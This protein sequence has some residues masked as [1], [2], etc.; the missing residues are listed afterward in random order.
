MKLKQPFSLVLALFLVIFSQ[1]L[2]AWD[3]NDVKK[4]NEAIA[5]F[6]KAD[7]D[8]QAF[9]DQARGYAVFPTVGKG[10]F[11]LGGAYGK[12]VV[13]E[14]GKPIGNTSVT[15][16]T[17]GFQLG[18]QA[19]REVI[20]FKDKKTLDDFKQ[21]NYELGAQASAVAVKAGVSADADYK[22]GVAVFTIAKGGLMYEAS[23][24]GQKFSYTSK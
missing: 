4:A 2:Q 20:F 6:K 15:Q 14:Q 22:N 10:G 24:G 5:E 11:G 1:L 16:L 18:G 23:V 3:A 7:P 12:G 21:G 8:L 13:Y 9:F 19:Y 17:I